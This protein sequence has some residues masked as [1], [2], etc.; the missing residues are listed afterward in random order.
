MAGG[1]GGGVV[2]RKQRREFCTVSCYQVGSFVYSKG[3]GGQGE[4]GKK[5]GSGHPAR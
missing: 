2:E 3:G 1:R 4:G 5:K